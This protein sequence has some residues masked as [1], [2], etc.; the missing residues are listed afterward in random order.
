MERG[1]APL[2]GPGKERGVNLG[3]TLERR[4]RNWKRR[5][6][7]VH[8]D[9]L[10]CR[11]P[12]CEVGA[13]VLALVDRVSETPGRETW[14]R[15][16]HGGNHRSPG[17]EDMLQGEGAQSPHDVV[18]VAAAVA[19]AGGGGDV[20]GLMGGLW[21]GLQ[22]K[23]GRDLGG[24]CCWLRGGHRE[25]VGGDPG[26]TQPGMGEKAAY[27]WGADWRQRDWSGEG[28]SGDNWAVPGKQGTGRQRQKNW[29]RRL[30]QSC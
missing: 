19:V 24:H 16:V 26:S 13:G 10:G 12:G 1:R 20:L 23:E 7:G 29:K 17:G 21:T 4:K 11:T 2:G 18:V 15:G 5:R 28:R 25:E 30:L 9:L 6:L 3:R 8:W 27:T 14:H 22:L